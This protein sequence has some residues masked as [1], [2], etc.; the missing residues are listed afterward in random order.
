MTTYQTTGN[1]NTMTAG[2]AYMDAVYAGQTAYGQNAY[3]HRSEK[4]QATVKNVKTQTSSAKLFNVLFMFVVVAIFLFV[5]VTLS[6]SLSSLQAEN[7]K[8]QA[9]NEYIQA[10]INS[11]ES[12]LVEVTNVTKIEKTATKKYGMVYPSAS[13]CITISKD[14]SAGDKLASTIKKEAYN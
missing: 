8:I 2:T 5:P 13:N 14:D 11:I 9:E 1:L 10:E 12:Q 3:G 4:N 7:N 6:S